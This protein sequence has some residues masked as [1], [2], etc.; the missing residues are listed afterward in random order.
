MLRLLGENVRRFV[1]GIA[2]AEIAV[3][4]RLS[5]VPLPAC[6]SQLSRRHVGGLLDRRRKSCRGVGD[7]PKHAGHV[8][9]WRRLF[10][11]LLERSRRLSLEVDD[12]E[13]TSRRPKHLAEVIIPVHAGSKA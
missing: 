8:S 3:E 6:G 5:D 4:I 11:S 10:S 2:L 1:D 7:A 9:Q 12:R 13:I